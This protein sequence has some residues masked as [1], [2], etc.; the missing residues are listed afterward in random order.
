MAPNDLAVQAIATAALP[1]CTYN[2]GTAGVGAT[3][4]AS[5]NGAFPVVDGYTASLNDALAVNGQA[6]TT[7]NGLY[8]LTTV[9]NGSTPWVLTRRS[10][11]DATIWTNPFSVLNGNKYKNTVWCSQ[12][13]ASNVGT[14]S[15][16]FAQQANLQVVGFGI[17]IDG[18][19]YDPGTGSK[20]YITLPYSGTI[21]NWYLAANTAGSCVID[22][23]RSGTSIVGAGN[24]P[25]LSSAQ[26]GNAAV[27][28]WTSTAVSAGDII[29]FNLNSITT[30][31]RVN[32]MIQVTRT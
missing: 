13:V 2:N 15:I 30:I 20:G 9:G 11:D 6:T 12:T 27:S 19:G 16:N 5:S 4:T 25:T 8:T 21:T 1:T 10:P 23:K 32:L 3:L 18:N 7:Q 24:K 14:D 17:T 22:V 31:T 29:E 28:S 26:S